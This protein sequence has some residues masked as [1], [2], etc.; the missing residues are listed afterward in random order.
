MKSIAWA[1]F[2]TSMLLLTPVEAADWQFVIDDKEVSL[3][4]NKGFSAGIQ[5]SDEATGEDTGIAVYP[6]ARMIPKK[7]KDG[8]GANL[9]I[10]GGKYGMK[11]V[12]ARLESRDKPAEIVAFY[13]KELAKVGNVIACRNTMNLPFFDAPSTG[14][15]PPPDRPSKRSARAK[16]LG[17]DPVSCDNDR[18]RKDGVLIKAGTEHRQRMAAVEPTATGSRL[19]LIRLDLR[20]LD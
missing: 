5:I 9:S 3:N 18:P 8:S 1:L 4:S 7:T 2:T 11:L 19:T 16:S 14:D 20:G 17:T 6:G 10:H 13:E 12:V 15:A